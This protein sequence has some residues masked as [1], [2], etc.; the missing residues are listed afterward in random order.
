M[1]VEMLK[2]ART[3]SILCHIDDFLL[4][5]VVF[6]AANEDTL[7]PCVLDSVC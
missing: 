6:K 5:I 2:G 7:R 4:H 1:D 3:Q